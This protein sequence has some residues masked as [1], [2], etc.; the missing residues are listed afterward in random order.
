MSEAT[1]SAQF[2]RGSEEQHETDDVYDAR[3]DGMPPEHRGIAPAND[4][5]RQDSR[6]ANQNEAEEADSVHAAPRNASHAARC[7]E[8]HGVRSHPVPIALVGEC[9]SRVV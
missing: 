3:C 2:A 4:P 7:V 1:V 9:S 6:R 8:C 5:E